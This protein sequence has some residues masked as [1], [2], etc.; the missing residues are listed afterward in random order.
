M[1]LNPPL[2][3]WLCFKLWDRLS[4]RNDQLLQIEYHRLSSNTFDKYFKIFA[5]FC[6]NKIKKY[7]ENNVNK[8]FIKK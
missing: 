8:Y 6:L 4:K 1:N 3:V 5:I 2:E 7:F